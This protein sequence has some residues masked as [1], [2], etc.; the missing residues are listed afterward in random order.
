MSD[1]NMATNPQGIG[2]T[3]ATTE[4]DMIA[5]VKEYIDRGINA[6]VNQSKVAAEV[7][8]LRNEIAGM[9]EQVEKVRRQNDWLDEQLVRIRGER[10]TAVSDATSARQSRDA[11]KNII[12]SLQG[13]LDIAKTELG[14]DAELV[15][16]LRKERDDALYNV[17]EQREIISKLQGKIERFLSLADEIDRL[18]EPKPQQV[19]VTQPVAQSW[20]TPKPFEPEPSTQGQ[21][22]SDTYNPRAW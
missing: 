8:S 22:A 3:D 4:D 20:N 18:E 21:S 16:T 5:K 19:P 13:Q 14:K 1:G 15:E 6:L 9:R 7:E 2:S 11:A 10:D 17:E 12:D